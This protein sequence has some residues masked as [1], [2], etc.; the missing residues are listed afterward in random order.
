MKNTLLLISSLSLSTASLAQN[1]DTLA[2]ASAKLDTV[3]VSAD[4]RQLDLM[5]I[6]SAITV[7]DAQAIENRNADHLESILSLAPN[8]NFATG[9]SRARYFQIRGI[10]ERSQF[11]DSVNPSVGLIIDGIDMTGL[12]GAATLFDIE[13]V[14]ILRG[15][16]GT[17]F[18]A[19]ALAGAINIKSK[20]PTKE[21]EGYVNA[22][23][24][25]YNT[26]GLGGALSG[27]LTDKLQSRFAINQTLSDGY[28]DN[29]HL[30]RDDTNNIDELVARAQFTYKMNAKN[31]I[32][33]SLL[34]ADIDNGYDTFSL[35]NTRETY[36]D[37]PGEDKQETSASSLT[38]HNFAL[39]N[40]ALMLQ[41]TTS[42]S[43]VTYSYD[44]DWSFPEIDP[45]SYSNTDEYIRNF[46]RNSIETRAT[47]NNNS[48]IFNESTDWTFGVYQNSKKESLTRAYNGVFSNQVE[49]SSIA[50]YTEFTTAISP[51][52]TLTSGLRIEESDIEYTDSNNT[53]EQLNETLWG[54]KA[55][56]D[57]ML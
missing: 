40:A 39:E 41:V 28:I 29:I 15:P 48:R 1:E 54:G 35:D 56:I 22:K 46:E 43:D 2:D 10:G 14:E 27:S 49:H 4:F 26:Q 21:T 18:G 44:E 8:A 6:P 32:N 50:T 25:N 52:T 42:E 30:N 47:S 55:T 17:V 16:Q 12:G 9:A 34:K 51:I 45:A 7:V 3:K 38:W 53:I 37:Q 20:Q 24:G 19:N 11:I 5:Q 36:S 31:D 57:H 23:I 33:I 13:Q